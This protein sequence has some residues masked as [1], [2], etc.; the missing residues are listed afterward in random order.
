VW[1]AAINAK[2]KR[3]FSREFAQRLAI[4]RI[5]QKRGK[6][7]N[8]KVRLFSGIERADTP[9]FPEGEAPP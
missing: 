7:D 4:F 9:G 6:I 3:I 8:N 1:A 2:R 5:R